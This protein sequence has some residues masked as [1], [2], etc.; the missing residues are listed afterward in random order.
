MRPKIHAP[1]FVGTH[2]M[3]HDLSGAVR[4]SFTPVAGSPGDRDAGRTVSFSVDCDWLADYLNFAPPG[5]PPPSPVKDLARI[6]GHLLDILDQAGVRATFF[7]IAD[8]LAD[9]DV[10]DA[11]RD[12]VAAGH[13]IGNHTLTHPAM[14][15]LDAAGVE[16]EIRLGHE[17][18]AE[19]L[20]REPRGYRGPAYHLTART[21]GLLVRLGYHYDSSA[22]RQGINGLLAGLIGLVLR[23]YRPKAGSRMQRAIPAFGPLLADLGPQGRI[24]E[25]P[26]PQA[27]GLPYLGTMHSVAPKALFAF[28]TRLLLARPAHLHYELHLIEALS[29]EQGREHPWIPVVSLRRHAPRR[30]RRGWLAERLAVLVGARTVTTLEE[31]CAAHLPL[32]HR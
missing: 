1:H 6:I 16:A 11:F 26:I 32:L 22:C 24:L 9:P 10:R 27:A 17:A 7:C 18:I 13:E 4:P 5:I 25:W 30:D 23:D 15:G 19:A 2:G 3:D 12:V 21:L 31:R 14:D 28:Q 20:G 29:E 8:R